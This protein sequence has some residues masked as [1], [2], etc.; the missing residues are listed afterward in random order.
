MG[1]NAGKRIREDSVQRFKGLGEMNAE[2]LRI[3]TMDQ[4]H[5]VLGQVT[6]DDAAQADDLFSVLDGRGRRGPG[7]RSSSATPRTS[8]S[9]T[10]ESVSADRTRKD[11]HQ[12]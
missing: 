2:E 6:L 5:R 8:A 9:S 10:S 3:T 12:Q 4:E 1:R 11:L 7:A